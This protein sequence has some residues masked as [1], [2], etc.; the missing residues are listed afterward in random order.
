M[1]ADDFPDAPHVMVL[2]SSHGALAYAAKC[3]HCGDTHA[4]E[5]LP[6]SFDDLI[7]MWKA[8]ARRHAECKP[9]G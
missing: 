2:D 9:R 4:P 7:A 5:K 6:A 3:E 1:S 8:F